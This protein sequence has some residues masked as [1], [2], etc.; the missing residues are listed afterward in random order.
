MYV[1]LALAAIT[2]EPGLLDSPENGKRARS[3]G[4]TM[5]SN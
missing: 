2:M 1:P 3:A 5:T 4:Q